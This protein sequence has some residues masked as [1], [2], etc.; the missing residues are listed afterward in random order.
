ML[1]SRGSA[2]IQADATKRALGWSAMTTAGT[3]RAGSERRDEI[4]AIA[5]QLFAERGFAATTVREIADAAGILSG[6][7]LPPL[8]LEGVDGRRAGARDARPGRWRAYRRDRRHRRRPRRSRCA[9][10]C[11]KRSPRS[12]TDRATVAVMVNEWNL[13]V[14][15]PRFAYLRDDLRGDRAPLGGRDRARRASRARSAPTST[16]GCSTG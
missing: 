16:R 3:V 15:F 1:S 2:S 10:W 8:R 13:F 14:Q 6:Q 7:P 5:A 11:A 4:L 9:R 12:P